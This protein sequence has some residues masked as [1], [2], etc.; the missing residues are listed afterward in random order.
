[1]RGTARVQCSAAPRWRDWHQAT[2]L[3]YDVTDP[4]SRQ[5]TFCSAC[6][7][8]FFACHR[9]TADFEPRQTATLSEA[10]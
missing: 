5:Y 8:L 2:D 9:L 1:M 10:A 3:H 4:E 6:C 7:F